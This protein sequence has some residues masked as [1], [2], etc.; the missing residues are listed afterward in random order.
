MLTIAGRVR[1]GPL[2]SGGRVH[3][4]VAR[5]VLVLVGLIAAALAGLGPAHAEGPS[6]TAVVTG[7]DK[8]PVAGV[9][10]NVANYIACL[11]NTAVRASA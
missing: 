9:T 6:I 10:V 8:A 11:I 5:V 2:T 7:A 1:L 4:V 3:R